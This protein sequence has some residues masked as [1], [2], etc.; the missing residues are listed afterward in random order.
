MKE[1]HVRRIDEIPIELPVNSLDDGAASTGS[2]AAKPVTKKKREALRQALILSTESCLV[3]KT[4]LPQLEVG[5]KLL[6]QYNGDFN[7]QIDEQHNEWFEIRLVKRIRSE[8]QLSIKLRLREW[9]LD[10][11]NVTRK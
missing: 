7:G 6:L 5:Q 3:K 8:G 11:V 9:E 2:A 10:L 4:Q 1:S